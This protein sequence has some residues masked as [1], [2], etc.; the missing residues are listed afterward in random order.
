L[1]YAWKRGEMHTKLWVENV[2]GRDNSEDL[3]IDETVILEWIS[4]K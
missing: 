1:F 4:G 2:K 3:G